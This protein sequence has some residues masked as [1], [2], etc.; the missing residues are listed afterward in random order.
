MCFGVNAAIAHSI[1][2]NDGKIKIKQVIKKILTSPV[3]ITYV[4]LIA[5]KLLNIDLPNVFLELTSVAGGANAFL[6]MLCIG[7]L[8][9]FKLSKENWKLVGIL[10]SLRISVLVCIS[11]IIYFLIPLP[12]DIKIAL[13]VILMAPCPSAAPALTESYGGDG[14]VSAVIN[15]ISIPLSMIFMSL[16]LLIL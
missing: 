8:F 15:S 12:E 6:A 1:S 5:L 13:C 14:G 11:L 2:G 3:F 7:I 9:Q 16:F 10:L 4:V